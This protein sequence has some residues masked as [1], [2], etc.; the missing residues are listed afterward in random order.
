M[1]LWHSTYPSLKR[2]KLAYTEFPV[3][4][5]EPATQINKTTSDASGGYSQ[6]SSS[7]PNEKLCISSQYNCIIIQNVL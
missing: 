3:D 2:V 5:Q 1:Y 4:L 6:N 7:Y